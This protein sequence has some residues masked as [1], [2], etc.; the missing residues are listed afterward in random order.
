VPA[1]FC[2]KCAP[3]HRCKRIKFYAKY[4]KSEINL[5]F[6]RVAG[7]SSEGVQ[8][9]LKSKRPA[10]KNRFYHESEFDG[11]PN[12]L[13]LEEFAKLPRKR[14]RASDCAKV[15]KCVY[16]GKLSILENQHKEVREAKQSESTQ[17]QEAVAHAR[18]LR[19]SIKRRETENTA[20][21]QQDLSVSLPPNDYPQMPRIPKKSLAY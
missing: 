8:S 5:L 4:P 1:Y 9:E 7:E 11:I 13:N 17:P 6:K 19:S 10:W 18:T 21:T 12:E 3:K 14:P 20:Q 15:K 16:Y 2:L